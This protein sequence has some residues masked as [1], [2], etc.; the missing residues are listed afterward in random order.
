MQDH[1]VLYNSE[2]I[3]TDY[4]GRDYLEPAEKAVLMELEEKLKDMDMLDMGV[5]GGR[6]T[7]YFAPLV[8]NY[9]GAD[10]APAMIEACKNKYRGKY[11]FMDSDA[12]SM[13]EFEDNTFD[14]ILFSYNGI[15]SFNHD[16]RMAALKE[17]RRVLK[18]NGYFCFSSHNL[19]WN[20]LYDLFSF[21]AG[22]KRQ[23]I[24]T[25]I[26]YSL[27][28]LKKI[29]GSK[30]QA[31][32]LRYLNKNLKM[33]KFIKVLRK[34]ESGSLYDNSLNGKANVYYITR[35]QQ[36]K[37]LKDSGFTHIHAYSREGEKT[38][39]TVEL[40]KSGWIYYLCQAKKDPSG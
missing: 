16:D 22:K 27:R 2:S 11:L 10:Y 1:R 39:S 28:S 31:L 7:K 32:R 34:N 14:F 25:G 5:G 36:V 15:D 40:N 37:Q 18:N 4:A 24:G 38:D 23:W 21:K 29:A 35:S 30:Y 19:N 3:S 8:K 26:K 20:D 12:R 17:I 33:R 9:I 6:T 13:A